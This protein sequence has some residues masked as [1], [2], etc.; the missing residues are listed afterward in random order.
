M[1]HVVSQPS[2]PF[3]FAQGSAQVHMVPAATDNLSWLIEYLP[4]RV[5][6]V[7]GPSLG[8]I[9]KYCDHLNLQITHLINTHIHG[10]HIGVNH[11]LSRARSERPEL[12]SETIEVWGAAKTAKEIPH[13]THPLEEGD[14]LSLGA[15]RG[16][17]WLTEGHLNGHLS[18]LFWSKESAAVPITGDQAALFCGDT[19]FAAGC[20]R[21]FDGPPK[22]MYDS[23]QRICSLPKDTALFCAHEYTEDNL[24]FARFTSPMNEAIEARLQSCRERRSEG[25]STIPTSVELELKTNPF[26]LADSVERFAELRSMKDHGAHRS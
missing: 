5:A 3:E 6:V 17:V 10:D 9:L 16:A 25:K 1:S 24:A 18:F 2:P 15:L 8:P 4:Q 12:F 26:V 19:L 13:L 14:L 21:L 7:D 23:L 22:K 20:G 11:G